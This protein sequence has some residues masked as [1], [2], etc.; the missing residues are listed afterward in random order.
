MK[1]LWT[2][3][4]VRDLDATINFYTDLVGLKVLKRFQ[5]GPNTEI[6]FMGNGVDGETKLEFLKD[7]SVEPSVPG[8]NISIGFAVNSVNDMIKKVKENGITISKDLFETPTS[9]F[10]YVKDPNG[11]NVQFFQMK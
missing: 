11:L 3:L 4:Y 1:F 2:A 5:A 6:A 7:K 8:E 9:S 10:F